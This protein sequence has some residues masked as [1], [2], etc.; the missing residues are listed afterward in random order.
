[1]YI[2]AAVLIIIGVLVYL[3]K[4]AKTS[5][6]HCANTKRYVTS[7]P[8]KNATF[9]TNTPISI[10][11]M[12]LS[13]FTIY[14]NNITA[15][16]ITVHNTKD[17]F[18]PKSLKFSSINKYFPNALRVSYLYLGAFPVTKSNILVIFTGRVIAIL[19]IIIIKK[20]MK[21]KQ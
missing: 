5:A 2:I 7:V 20:L 17:M 8:I 9:A 10:F 3:L 15:R 11:N 6:S 13:F 12:F 21:G 16:F 4:A 19:N 14:V 18:T 1:M